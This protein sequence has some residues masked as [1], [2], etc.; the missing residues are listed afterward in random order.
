MQISRMD[1][2]D[3]GSPEGLVGIILRIERDL[4]IPVPIEQLCHQL[5]IEE[6]APLETEGFEGG[7]LTDRARS[8]GIVLVN[9]GSPYQRR[10]FTIGHESRSFPHSLSATRPLRP[11]PMLAS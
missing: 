6:I 2:A 1:L 9:D 5:D 10:R 4:P 8:R 11:I 3:T 7:L